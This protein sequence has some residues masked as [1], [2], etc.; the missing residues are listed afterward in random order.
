MGKGM[1]NEETEI[2][3]SGMLAGKGLFIVIAI[4]VGLLLGISS[5]GFINVKPTDVA[6]K[7]DKMGNKIDSTPKAMGYHL[8]NRWVTDMVIYTVA[9]RSFPPN[10]AQSEASDKYTLDL[11]TNDGQA[12][13]VDLTV[14]YCL[15][16]NE[17]SK[18]HQ[19]VGKGYEDQVLLPI[20]RSEARI[21][22]GGY[23]A[24][25][26]Y[27]GKVRDEIQKN[28]KEKLILAVSK[29]P[30]I[31]IQD[32]MLRHFRFNGEFEKAIEAKKIAAQNVEVNKQRALAQ[33]EE[34]K[35][36]EAEATGG[37]LKAIQEAQGRAQS[38][39]T[40]ADASRYA[41]EQEAKGNLA[42]A[43]A[44]AE[45]KRLA[46][47]ALGSGRNLVALEFAKNIPPTMKGYIVP[48]GQNTTNLMDLN[49]LT[50]GLFGGSGEAAAT[51]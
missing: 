32:A 5:C 48:A 34:S 49:G 38:V 44:D 6:I 33:M 22:I 3:L 29:Y 27:Q 36:I 43:Q 12:I 30:A 17:V 14:L 24:E 8:Y 46:A 31:Q 47:N 23:S 2:D 1:G 25:E 28:I 50:K 4:V 7:I 21:I 37:K 16:A 45:G 10:V 19:E 11:K 42:L 39:K 26:I 20:V 13:N 51:K 40:E 9:T 15:R 35:R 41:K 18:L